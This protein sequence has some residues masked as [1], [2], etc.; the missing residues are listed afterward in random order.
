MNGIMA[1]KALCSL[2]AKYAESNAAFIPF[3]R[4]MD[5]VLPNFNEFFLLLT[6]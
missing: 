1:I 4:D 5:P 6:G 3:V 2:K